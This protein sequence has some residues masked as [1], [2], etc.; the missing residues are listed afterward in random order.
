MYSIFI[1]FKQRYAHTHCVTESELLDYLL[2]IRA[3]KLTR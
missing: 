1:G 2:N 3:V